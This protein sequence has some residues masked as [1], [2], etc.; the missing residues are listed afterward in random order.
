MTIK[1]RRK[2]KWNEFKEWILFSTFGGWQFRMLSG[3]YDEN[4]L[5]K[6]KDMSSSSSLLIL[7]AICPHSKFNEFHTLPVTHLKYILWEEA[8]WSDRKN[9]SISCCRS[10][11]WHF[12]NDVGTILKFLLDWIYIQ[13]NW[14]F[15]W[16]C[17]HKK[18]FIGPMRSGQCQW[19]K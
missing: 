9:W 14:I 15:L 6:E 1:N 17:C 19:L 3:F 5:T 7:L 10:C 16:C 12:S 4:F 8:K 13:I 2:E 11:L 18:Q